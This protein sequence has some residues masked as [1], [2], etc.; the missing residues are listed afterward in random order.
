MGMREI[1]SAMYHLT[2]LWAPGGAESF[3]CWV[4]AGVLQGCPLSGLLFTWVVAPLLQAMMVLLERP[5]LAIIRACADDIGAV[6]PEL[7][8]LMI[9]FDLF[10][11][12][13]KGAGLRLF[14][15]PRRRL[16]LR[17]GG[18]L[19]RGGGGGSGEGAVQLVKDRASV[20]A[21]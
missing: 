9:L 3:F 10:L 8:S 16:A 6:M 13:E 20:Q 12:V 21:G 14:F 19:R 2:H 15:A 7:R 18:G 11:K 1:V 17:E 5:R 4:A